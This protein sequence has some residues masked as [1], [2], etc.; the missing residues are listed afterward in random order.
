MREKTVL[1]K[2][3]S[4][5]VDRT[6]LNLQSSDSDHHK[7]K[8]RKVAKVARQWIQRKSSVSGAN[9]RCT[10][11]PELR[12]ASV[13]LKSS[14]KTDATPSINDTDATSQDLACINSIRVLQKWLELDQVAHEDVIYDL[15]QLGYERQVAYI[16]LENGTEVIDLLPTLSNI[17]RVIKAHGSENQQ[18]GK[19]SF[20]STYLSQLVTPGELVKSLKVNLSNALQYDMG[21]IYPTN[22]ALSTSSS[23]TYFDNSG[24]FQNQ[25]SVYDNSIMPPPL[26]DTDIVKSESTV[27][28]PKQSSKS[29]DAHIEPLHALPSPPLDSGSRYHRSTV[30]EKRSNSNFY[31]KQYSLETPEHQFQ[32]PTKMAPV[33]ETPRMILRDGPSKGNAEKPTVLTPQDRLSLSTLTPQKPVKLGEL[34]PSPPKGSPSDGAHPSPESPEGV[35]PGKGRF[36]RQSLLRQR[37]SLNEDV[38]GDKVEEPKNSQRLSFI[39][40]IQHGVYSQPT[41]PSTNHSSIRPHSRGRIV[42]NESGNT[43]PSESLNGAGDIL[44]Q[45]YDDNLSI[46]AVT[47]D[48]HTDLEHHRL[49]QLNAVV[50]QLINDE[51]N[52]LAELESHNIVLSSSM[53]LV[54]KKYPLSDPLIP[55]NT[56]SRSNPLSS[57]QHAPPLFPDPTSKLKTSYPTAVSQRKEMDHLILHSLA[58]SELRNDKTGGATRHHRDSNAENRTYFPGIC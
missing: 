56:K 43:K 38:H 39:G 20:F 28:S 31:T 19:N 8:F 36:V 55:S 6:E 2:V 27:S 57:T 45:E 5:W 4:I 50:N 58:N 25:E 49:D 44:E 21:S 3:L 41:P 54:M 10:T 17:V 18:V 32:S 37:S 30:R 40:G 29:I 1:H 53:P 14:T 23:S 16:S 46:I 13:L 11:P 24:G 34:K 51:E 22:A 52:L 47:T 9:L 33:S 12:R 26:Q 35:S 7:T 15:S 42:G 48:P